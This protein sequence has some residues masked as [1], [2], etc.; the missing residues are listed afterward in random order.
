MEFSKILALLIAV[1]M[2]W[3]VFRVVSITKKEK[4]IT[5]YKLGKLIIEVPVIIFVFC[6]FIYKYIL[7]A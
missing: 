4:Q 6:W 5:H 2:L 3:D 1:T 7:C